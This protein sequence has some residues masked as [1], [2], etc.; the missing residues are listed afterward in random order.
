MNGK[1]RSRV[2]RASLLLLG[3]A[4]VF[5]LVK[6]RHAAAEE[7][8]ATQPWRSVGAPADLPTL[9][10]F[11]TDQTTDEGEEAPEDTT[12][13]FEPN[14]PPPPPPSSNK[15]PSFALPDTG[16][17]G[18]KEAPLETLGPGSN[19]PFQAAAP[20]PLPTGPKLRRGVFGL[21]PMFLLIGL[22]AI[23]IFVVTTVIK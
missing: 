13:R 10:S 4:A 1:V 6:A 17:G 5:G 16:R 3:A 7:K 19:R 23:H 20:T 9:L 18:F 22:V 21:H 2:A 14:T 15:Q 8:P 11:A 12:G